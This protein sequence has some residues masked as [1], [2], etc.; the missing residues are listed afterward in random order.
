MFCKKNPLF[1]QS[2]IASVQGI[3]E[4]Y[5]RCNTLHQAT[6]KGSV[7]CSQNLGFYI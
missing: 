7:R 4:V 3:M 2:L 6:G 1:Y 5:L